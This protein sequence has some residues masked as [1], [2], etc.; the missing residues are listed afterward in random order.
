MSRHFICFVRREVWQL[1]P[2]ASPSPPYAE[3]QPLD[4]GFSRPEYHSTRATSW[5]VTE[6]AE[7]DTVW[8]VAQLR[9]RGQSLPPALDARID[10]AQVRTP[11]RSSGSRSGGYRFRAAPSSRWFPLADA[12]EVLRVLE[13]RR[14]DGGTAPLLPNGQESIGRVTRWMRALRDAVKLQEWAS[15]LEERAPDVVSYRHIDGTERAFEWVR[16]LLAKRVA[17]FWDRWSLPRRLAERRETVGEGPL[18]RCIE[19]AIRAAPNVWGVLSPLYDE[20]RSYSARE[21]ALAEQLGTFRAIA[22]S[23]GDLIRI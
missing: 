5:P 14:R 11:P 22:P 20:P 7:G 18:D 2:E 17:I 16:E 4:A 21:K 3:Q 19:D 15:A 12:T 9:W 6:V 8:L 1:P 13:T 10:V 23:K